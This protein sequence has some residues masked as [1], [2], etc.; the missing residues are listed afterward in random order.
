MSSFSSPPSFTDEYHY[1]LFKQLSFVPLA[2]LDTLY[3][4]IA[5]VIDSPDITSYLELEDK[6]L[7]NDLVTT[8]TDVC[9]LDIDIWNCLV[10]I[11]SSQ[12]KLSQCDDIDDKNND[13]NI[14]S[15][16]QLQI[17]SQVTTLR[18]CRLN[19]KQKLS[20]LASLLNRYD[21]VLRGKRYT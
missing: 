15:T 4:N 3:R 20:E 8:W 16:L 9:D 7:F 19:F 12:K 13:G 6:K 2:L 17:Y 5:P 1:N 18:R 11:H 14:K 21:V 10:D